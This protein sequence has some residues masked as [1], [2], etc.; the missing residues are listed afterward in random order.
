MEY[1]SKKYAFFSHLDTIFL[2]KIHEHLAPRRRDKILEVGCR[3][4]LLVKKMQEL[5]VDAYGIDINPQAIAHGTAKNL[6]VADATCLPFADASFNKIYSIHTIEHIP[7]VRKALQEMERVLIP[8]GTIMLVYPAE[9][10]RGMFALSAAVIV[11]KKP[12]LC[13]AIHIHKL[14]PKKIKELIQG[15]KLEYVESHFPVLLLPQFLTVLQKSA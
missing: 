11:Y 2:P 3:R 10:I 1:N 12:S 15:L 9:I 6:T 8:G 5:G 14:F 13:R 7:N 4:G